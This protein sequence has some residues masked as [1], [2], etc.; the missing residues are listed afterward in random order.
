MAGAYRSACICRQSFAFSAFHYRYRNLIERLFEKLKHTRGLATR[1][2]KCADSFLAAIKIFS[3]PLWINALSLQ[4]R[5]TTKDCEI[6][7]FEFANLMLP[8]PQAA[9]ISQ[10]KIYLPEYLLTLDL[11]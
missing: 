10:A 7:H 8:T 2:D 1:Y 5:S 4:P 11:A 6:L 3:A 9:I